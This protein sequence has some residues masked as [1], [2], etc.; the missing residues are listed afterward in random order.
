MPQLTKLEPSLA[1]VATSVWRHKFTMVVCTGV[2]VAL[3]VFAYLMIVPVYEA[4]TA[5]VIG[6]NAPDSR[7]DPARKSTTEAATL[8]HVAGSEEVI[9]DAITAVG[10]S[11]LK[12]GDPTMGNG[13]GGRLRAFFSK[14]KPEEPEKIS[15]EDVAVAQLKNAISVRTDPSS[16]VIRI[17]FRNVD[18]AL[19]ALFAN[20]LGEAFIDRQIKLIES[21]GVVEFFR[22]QADRFNNEVTQRSQA[23]EAFVKQNNVYSIDDQRNL[24]LKRRS[25]LAAQQSAT[26]TSLADIEAR[27]TTVVSQLRLL[28][29][30]TLSPYISSLVDEL[31]ANSDKRVPAP[32]PDAKT[33]QPKDP[34]AKDP[35][36]AQP[37]PTSGV[38]PLL[39]VKVYQD[40]M[41]DLFKFNSEIAGYRS[42]SKQQQLEIDNIDGELNAL[43]ATQ[44]TFEKLKREVALA[45][46]NAEVFA[47]RT[48]EEQIDNDLHTAKF[49]TVR[50]IERALIP[51]QAAFPKGKVFLGLGF[52][53]GLLMGIAASLLLDLFGFG[54]RK[55]SSTVVA[56]SR[57]AP[58]PS[59][60]WAKSG[61]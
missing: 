7:Q 18:P 55:S 61:G 20:A 19:A 1:T 49:S 48:V 26:R 34:A 29:Q 5:L 43:T 35:T 54:Q 42:L 15:P 2:G 25:E 13:L 50:V 53:F 37:S 60:S 51:L 57:H 56:N 27:K 12:L 21:P 3:A 11:R 36:A 38:P 30:V 32:R 44:T 4:T 41:V 59:A 40:I 28:K 22:R 46:Y 8:A 14:T 47:K 33:Q 45:S 24:L 10:V 39:M 23:F 17:S 58:A 9:R 52:A 16:D 31:A 6:Q